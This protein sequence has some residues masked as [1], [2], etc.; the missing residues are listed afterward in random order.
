MSVCCLCLVVVEAQQDENAEAAAS[1]DPVVDGKLDTE[2]QP[3]TV[4]GASGT[5]CYLLN[6]IICIFLSCKVIL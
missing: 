5:S 3:E 6:S 2:Q 4:N 1:A